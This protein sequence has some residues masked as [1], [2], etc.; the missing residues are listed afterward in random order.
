MADSWTP[1]QI[2][3]AAKQL[4]SQIHTWCEK[5]GMVPSCWDCTLSWTIWG[6][7]YAK[8]AVFFQQNQ[9]SGFHL[10][11]FLSCMVQVCK[12]LW[13]WPKCWC[14]YLCWNEEHLV[15]WG[16][17]SAHSCGLWG[18][19]TLLLMKAVSFIHNTRFIYSFVQKTLTAL[20]TNTLIPWL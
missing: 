19:F 13:F 11:D 4:F 15:E 8:G 20:E 18:V 2:Y 12:Y 10:D 3:M 1:W 17:H 9:C 14:S 7:S 16:F 6:T 5:W